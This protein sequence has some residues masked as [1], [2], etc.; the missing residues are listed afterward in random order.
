MKPYKCYC[1]QL[2]DFFPSGVAA[3]KYFGYT[4]LIVCLS[5]IGSRLRVSQSQYFFYFF[6]FN[7]LW[8]LMKAV[9]FD[10]KKNPLKN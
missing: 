9:S 8:L 5:L 7:N 2:S 10:Q 6:F 1:M 3:Q 4:P